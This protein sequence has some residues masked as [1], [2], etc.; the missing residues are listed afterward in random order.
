MPS[1]EL[2]EKGKL[3]RSCE[4]LARSPRLTCETARLKV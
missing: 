1:L 3:L 2:S 4:F